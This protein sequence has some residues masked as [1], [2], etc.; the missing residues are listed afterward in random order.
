MHVSMIQAAA[1]LFQPGCW[2]SVA[3]ASWRPLLDPLPVDDY[4]LWL[5]APMAVAIAVVYKAIK[6]DDLT[7]LPRQAIWLAVQFVIVMAVAAAVLW[8][9]T[10]MV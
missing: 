1:L 10:E 9:V 2:A 3:S 4:W 5:M 7:P 6:L 8:L